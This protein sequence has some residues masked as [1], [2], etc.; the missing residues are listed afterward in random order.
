MLKSIWSDQ[1]GFIVTMELILIATI[2]GIGSIVG[3]TV[4]RDAV[5][6]EMA[7]IAD[8]IEAMEWGDSASKSNS[9]VN[10]SSANASNADSCITFSTPPSNER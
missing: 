4:V 6:S 9:N 5:N 10:N 8:A 7:D 2:I 1:E 3:F